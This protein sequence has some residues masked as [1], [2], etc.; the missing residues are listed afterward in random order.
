MLTFPGWYV[1][2]RGEGEVIVVNPRMIDA[3]ILTPVA[4]VLSTEH[5]KQI[6]RLFENKCRDVEF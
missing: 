6:A 3:A 4:P 5:I 1:I 2:V